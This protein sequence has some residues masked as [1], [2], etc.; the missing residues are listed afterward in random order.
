MKVDL[1]KIKMNELNGITPEELIDLVYKR[2][3]AKYDT[4]LFSIKDHFSNERTTSE[5]RK[6]IFLDYTETGLYGLP[7]NQKTVPETISNRE[8]IVYFGDIFS[9]K[10][11]KQ[12]EEEIVESS[13]KELL[14]KMLVRKDFCGEHRAKDLSELV[15]AD[16][17]DL[18]ELNKDELIERLKE[19]S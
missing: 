13:R 7:V 9:V 14:S 6:F 10:Q 5:F 12:T 17:K 1:S 3:L 18:F 15:Y 19:E 2:K 16:L 8:V 4:F 11:C